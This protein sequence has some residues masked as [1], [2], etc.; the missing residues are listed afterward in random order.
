MNIAFASSEAFPFCKT[1]GLADAV[2]ALSQEIARKE[3]NRVVLFLPHYRNI[4]N[5]NSLKAIKGSFV[6][7][8]EDRLESVSLSFVN[9]GSVIVFFVKNAK[10]FDREGFYNQNNKDFEDNDERFIFFNR[11]VLESLKYIGFKP[12]IIHCNDWQT[13]LIPAYLKTT[14]KTD[15]FFARSKTLLT[16]HNLAYQGHYSY[17]SFIKSG[18]GE[19]HYT[20]SGL[21]FYGGMNFL[22]G[23]LV[24]ADKVNTVSPTYAKETLKSNETAHGLKDVLKHRG[25]DYSGI[26]NGIDF[27]VWDPAMDSYLPVGYDDENYKKGKNICKNFLRKEVGLSESKTLPL[28]GIVSRIT[29]QKGL[30]LAVHAI[31]QLKDKAQFVILGSGEKATQQKFKELADEYEN[32][33]VVQKLD[34]PMAHKIYAGS[35]IFLMPS[36]FEPCGLS[37]MIAMRYGSVPVVSKV[38][39]LADTINKKNGFFVDSVDKEGILKTLREVVVTYGDKDKWD[40]LVVNCMQGDFSWDKSSSDYQ[41]LYDELISKK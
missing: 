28:V 16:V 23:G 32:I 21:E 9:W 37:Q 25:K 17:K 10:Y 31:E 6:V 15:A 39:G 13:G 12:H 29:Y 36:R 5:A 7:P 41:K 3:N 2:G 26:I 11:A 22:K 33:A 14:Y 30:D 34:E 20:T 27:E 1:G 18:L 40:K 38:G 4:S 19:K 24:Y 8:I 35:D